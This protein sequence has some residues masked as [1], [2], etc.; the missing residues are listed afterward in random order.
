[1]LKLISVAIPSFIQ[2]ISTATTSYGKTC[3][4]KC[5]NPF[6]YSGHFN[7]G[8][9]SRRSL[10]IR[11]V[12]IP[13]FI[14]GIS[15]Q[16][17][18]SSPPSASSFRSQSLPFF[19]AFQRRQKGNRRV[20]SS[21]CRNPFLFSGHFNRRTTARSLQQRRRGRNP[22]LFSGHFNAKRDYGAGPQI[23]RSQSLPFFRAFQHW[24]GENEEE[25]YNLSRNPFLFSG[26]FNSGGAIFD[27][28]LA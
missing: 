15:T 5:R 19:R 22:F 25:F 3:P 2:G 8:A 6:F 16:L 13:S 21:A 1:M 12:A 23:D 24:E 14:Q 4:P 18:R 7:R 10:G 17:G 28:R 9:D 20:R 27:Y 26:H 11:L